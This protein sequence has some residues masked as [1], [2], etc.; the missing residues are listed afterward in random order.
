M[1]IPQGT[2]KDFFFLA[3]KRLFSQSGVEELDWPA[4][5]PELLTLNL[6]QHL[7]DARLYHPTSGLHLANVLV[8]PRADCKVP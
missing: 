1:T 5:S 7:W 4:R 8:G 6:T 2:E 3:L